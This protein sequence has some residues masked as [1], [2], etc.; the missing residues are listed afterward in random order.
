LAVAPLPWWSQVV[1]RQGLAFVVAGVLGVAAWGSGQ[2]LQAGWRPL[3]GAT[4]WPASA[5][6]GLLYPEVVVRVPERVLGTPQ[7]Q[8]AIDPAC[9]GYEGM[10]LVTLLL[11][12]YLWL[13]RAHVRFPRAFLLL[14]LGLLA[15]WIANVLRI[16]LLIALGSSVWPALAA[17]GFHS[18]AGWLAFVTV[19]FGLIMG[20][21]RSPFWTTAATP[22]VRTP[23]ASTAVALVAPLVALLASAMLTTAFSSGVEWLYPLRLVVGG[24][25]LWRFRTCYTRL[26]WRWSWAAVAMGGV[27]FGVWLL[28]AP[29]ADSGQTA[30]AQGLAQL[31]AGLALG[32][33]ACRVV[34]AVLI[35]PLA[36]ELAFRGY[37]LRKLSGQEMVD[38]NPGR[39]TWGAVALS[40]LLFGAIHARWAA[41]TVAGLGY[42]LIAIRRGRLADAIVAHM[43]T[44]GLLA[45]WVLALREWS[46]WA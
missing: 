23:A 24:A 9:S 1:R 33:I 25:I 14:P 17:G 5:L 3:A 15:S 4:F 12:V 21:H 30:L 32:W 13:F 20:T 26:G 44:N 27:I 19:G 42:A 7:F 2:F 11:L 18:Q 28:L 40:S 29:T 16:T 36:E 31:P 46:L 6:L 38:L 39:W 10:G 34:G 22:A 35:V 45:V 43:T 37:A 8:V 41:G